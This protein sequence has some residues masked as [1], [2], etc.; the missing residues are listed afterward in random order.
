MA[1]K[2]FKT[3]RP[4]D[5]PDADSVDRPMTLSEHILSAHP[6]PNMAT[7]GSGE[8]SDALATHIRRRD[9]DS[10]GNVSDSPHLDTLGLQ[11]FAG[12]THNHDSVYSMLGHSHADLNEAIAQLQQSIGGSSSSSSI[13]LKQPLSDD[14]TRPLNTSDENS[15]LVLTSRSYDLD[16]QIAGDFYLF[17]GS[18]EKYNKYGSSG[19]TYTETSVPVLNAPNDVAYPFVL[20][21]LP[22]S[23]RKVENSD[24]N[25]ATSVYQIMQKIVDNAGKSWVRFGIAT[26]SQIVENV[27][28]TTLRFTIP[29]LIS[30][31]DLDSL[32]ER[33]DYA[34]LTD[35]YALLTDYAISGSYKYNQFSQRFVN[36]S[37]STRELT[38]GFDNG[39][40]VF[41]I[42]V[43]NNVVGTF[44]TNITTS[45]EDVLSSM[46]EVGE[47]LK[48]LS[49]LTLSVNDTVISDLI[50][51]ADLS[52]Y[53]YTELEE[54]T[55]YEVTSYTFGAWT[56]A[57]M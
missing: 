40:V 11:L 36:T 8:G 53:V 56:S 22:G 50:L 54:Q 23:V 15:E 3:K 17:I 10:E 38:I 49:G 42:L 51:D 46:T 5:L 4:L 16:K 44:T 14:T 24:G 55:R 41:N 12:R 13:G 37:D 27:E 29:D 52:T 39:V 18:D 45:L 35:Q 28:V 7:G 19:T 47:A 1:T 33:E 48:N 9:M 25:P 26:G 21:V 6:H 2:A 30:Q 43:D 20:T 34:E 57:V 32:S 31:A